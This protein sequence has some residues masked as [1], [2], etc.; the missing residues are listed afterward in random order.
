MAGTI[1][2]SWNGT[3]LTITS[4]SGTSSCDL[5]GDKGDDG[6]RGPQGSPGTTPELTGYA[7]ETYVNNSIA[8][9][10][11]VDLSGYATKS[12]VSAANYATQTYVDESIAAIPPTDLTDYATIEF[13]NQAIAD[14]GIDLSSYA[15]KTEVDTKIS[16]LSNIYAAKTDIPDVSQYQTAAEVSSTISTALSGYSQ[17]G[18]AHSQYLEASKIVY[19]ESEPSSPVSGM[20]WLKPAT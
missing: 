2:H 3:V 11:P 15:T 17:I 5:K 12:E 8:A 16:N 19:S 1:E 4:D 10:P 13:V 20:I 6:I 14:S 7:T 18:H 9:I